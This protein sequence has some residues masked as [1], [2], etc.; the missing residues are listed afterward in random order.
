MSGASNKA[1]TGA[2]LAGCIAGMTLVICV[3]GLATMCAAVERGHTGLGWVLAGVIS[4][5]A[6]SVLWQVRRALQCRG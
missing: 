5:G 6:G 3:F 1:W 4:L 2:V